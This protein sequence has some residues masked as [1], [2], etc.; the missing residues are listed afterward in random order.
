MGVEKEEEAVEEKEDDL[1]PAAA[2]L[3][4]GAVVV[5][6]GGRGGRVVSAGASV[7]VLV[8]VRVVL[9][10]LISLLLSY[11]G[12]NV[13]SG[14]SSSSC[15]KTPLTNTSTTSKRN[16]ITSDNTCF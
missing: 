2:A 12:K 10:D 4:G 15:P 3:T 8:G 14:R 5:L 9:A 1:S 13:K 11:S 7:V 16:I 6:V